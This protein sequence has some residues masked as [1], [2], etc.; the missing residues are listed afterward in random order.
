VQRDPRNT[1]A[2]SCRTISALACVL[3]LLGASLL[4]AQEPAQD[5]K[6]ADGGTPVGAPSIGG[7]VTRN[8]PPVTIKPGKIIRADV[9][10]ALVNVTVTD[11]YNRLVTGLDPDSF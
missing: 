8:T 2:V 5:T 10:L 1:R 4:R 7:D 9:D 3:S 6:P 11:P